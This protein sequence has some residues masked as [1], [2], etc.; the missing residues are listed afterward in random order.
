MHVVYSYRDGLREEVFCGDDIIIGRHEAGA[1]VDLDLRFDHLVSHIHARLW[2]GDGGCWIEDLGSRNGTYINGALIAPRSKQPIRPTDDVNIGDTRIH[3]EN[4]AESPAT[5]D[6]RNITLTLDAVKPAYRFEADTRVGNDQRLAILYELALQFGGEIQLDVLFKLIVRKLMETVSD[7]ARAALVLTNPETDTLLLKAHLPAGK[8]CVS[9]TLAQ[10]ALKEQ[11]AFIWQR[12]GQSPATHA[13][14]GVDSAMYAPLLWK[15]QAYGVICVDKYVSARVFGNDDLQLLV[16]IAQQAA[17]AV[18]NQLLQEELRR[19]STAKANLLRQFS[20]KIANRLLKQRGVLGGGGERSN[21]T[22]LFAD[23]REFSKL[24][25]SIGPESVVELL[26]SYFAAM[27]EVIF[28]HDGTVVQ[29]VG[30]TIFAVFGSPE[31][32]PQ[33]YEKGVSTAIEMQEKI[34][35][36]NSMRE[37]D[38]KPTCQFGIGV[39]CGEIVQGFIGGSDYLAYTVLGDPV[40]R[41]AR[42]CAAAKA[43]Q[44]LISPELY[45]RVWRIIR[46]AELVTIDAKFQEQLSAYN[47]TGLW[48]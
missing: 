28:S 15:G 2:V 35:N 39:H 45:E 30:D 26:N 16:A 33:H 40:N 24:T 32:D 44:V 23:M 18:A 31:P 6:G 27:S 7:S 46:D 4:T 19:E 22:I 37:K 10:R 47:V 36:V 9:M 25:R 11:V 21:V 42:Y 38:R 34:S 13:L 41:T 5:N 43:G 14:E 17:M 12:Q 1:N 3:V 29:Y 8:P 20:P 48:Q